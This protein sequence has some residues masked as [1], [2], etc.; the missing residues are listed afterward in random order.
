MKVLFRE[1]FGQFFTSETV[2][3]DDQLRQTLIWVIVFLFLPGVMLM[4]QLFFE[5]ESIVVHALRVQQFDQVEDTLEWI[6]FLYVTYSMVTVG[7]I[8]AI[9]WDGLSFDR[10]DAMVLGPLPLDGATIVAAKVGALGAFLLAASTAVNLPNAAAFAAVTG[11]QLGTAIVARHFVALFAATSLGAAFVFCCLVVLRGAVSA[12]SSAR[13]AAVTGSLLQFV[14]VLALLALVILCLAAGRMQRSSLVNP[15][16][17]GWLPAAWY[18]GL[19]EQ[20]RGST[21]VYF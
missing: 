7:F 4:L 16:A 14:F 15:I 13:A 18:L 1:F 11:N 21:R 6:A 3:S 12:V 2:T 8:A 9:G 19:F 20:M 17:T 5:F 10:R